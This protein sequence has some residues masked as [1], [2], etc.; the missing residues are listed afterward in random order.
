MKT[1]H[2]GGALLFTN[3][4]LSCAPAAAIVRHSAC[5]A[6]QTY[7]RKGLNYI[8]IA[9]EPEARKPAKEEKV[10]KKDDAKKMAEK[11]D[12]PGKVVKTKTA[13]AKAP[14]TRQKKKPAR[15]RVK[16]GTTFRLEA[17]HA[18]RVCVAGCFN[19]WNP[20]ANPLERDEEGIWKCTLFLEAGE[21]EYRFIVDDVWCDDPLNLTR[22][23]T[24]FGCENCVLIV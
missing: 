16:A 14:A 7:G 4:T 17:P 21:H 1:S 23:K 13:E 12:K 24:E 9:V 18:A 6:K 20:T 5:F 8:S 3:T 10:A 2:S 19:D 22:R 11:A 15:A